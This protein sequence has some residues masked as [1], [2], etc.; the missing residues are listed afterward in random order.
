MSIGAENPAN[1]QTGRRPGIAR[2]LQ[3][4][5]QGSAVS[6]ANTSDTLFRLA[7]HACVLA[8][9]AN[10]VARESKEIKSAADRTRLEAQDS[11]RVSSDLEQDALKA[12]VALRR[13][14]ELTSD[15]ATLAQLSNAPI[16]KIESIAETI[17]GN[18][19]GIR[20][21]TEKPC[22]LL[23]F[24]SAPAYS[25]AA[26]NKSDLCEN[27]QIAVQSLGT[28]AQAERE[29]LN[30][31]SPIHALH[32]YVEGVVESVSKVSFE[33]QH[34]LQALVL[35]HQ[36]AEVIS[37]DAATS[38]G[39][40]DSI[41]QHAADSAKESNRLEQ[42]LRAVASEMDAKNEECITNLILSGAPSLHRTLFNNARRLS[43]SIGEVL[44]SLLSKKLLT[45]EQL[46]HPVYKSIPNTNPQKFHTEFDESTDRLFPPYFE[47]FLSAN[48]EAIYAIAVNS[49]G[50]CPTHNA[51]FSKPL[52]GDYD[53]D[54]L[55]S[56]SK[57][58]FYDR[59]GQRS[60]SHDRAVLVQTHLRDTGEIFHDLSVPLYV[61]GRRWGAIRIGYPPT[62]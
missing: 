61:N 59:V 24:A 20:E 4:I 31:I 55:H 27:C 58:K 5:V 46:F 60:V 18:S 62:L 14:S 39:S 32:V 9:K 25:K 49:D 12:Q 33:L 40:A 41:F 28:L 44:E 21:L 54:L 2:S 8:R 56:R 45:E 13:I 10:E 3:E 52:T 42:E 23:P 36:R 11:A 26:A 34:V 16:K 48:P 43:E 22:A 53:V 47:D 17:R 38:A 29:V 7:S 57:R 6:I 35:M 51:R 15:A 30:S 37:A 50:Y 19:A 1:P